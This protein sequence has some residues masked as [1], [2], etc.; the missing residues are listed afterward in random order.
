MSLFDK[1]FKTE[2]QN[3][4]EKVSENTVNKINAVKLSNDDIYELTTFP[5]NFSE[6]F[7]SPLS[8]AQMVYMKKEIYKWYGIYFKIH[9]VDIIS[10]FKSQIT[11]DI[12]LLYNKTHD[13]E[14][15]LMI[16]DVVTEHLEE[17][18]ENLFKDYTEE[19]LIAWKPILHNRLWHPTQVEYSNL[20]G[21]SVEII[22]FYL[23]QN[24]DLQKEDLGELIRI[25]ENLSYS[26]EDKN[27]ERVFLIKTYKDFYKNQIVK[28]AMEKLLMEY[29][30]FTKYSK[31]KSTFDNKIY[32]EY[33]TAFNCNDY[34]ALFKT[35]HKRLKEFF[36]E[37]D[38]NDLAEWFKI[39]SDEILGFIV[40]YVA[41]L[42][43]VEQRQL[44][45]K[46]LSKYALSVDA[47]I[48]ALFKINMDGFESV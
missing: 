43:S 48:I 41:N 30:N 22:E 5:Y 21:K 28:N 7:K 18:L 19:E 26:D 6:E 27:N 24:I 8:N 35:V 13:E 12:C 40:D 37:H 31:T 45:Y 23:K 17:C 42:S 20:I 38:N 1:F 44:S 3:N 33:H 29:Y 2:Q 36:K 9:S 15:K 47:Y 16:S 34:N 32:I 39:N 46:D 25:N 14:Y 11:D 4:T 10:Q